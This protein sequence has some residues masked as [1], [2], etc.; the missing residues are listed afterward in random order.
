MEK[1]TGRHTAAMVFV[2]FCCLGSAV[3]APRGKQELVPSGHWVYDALTAVSLENG[4]RNFADCAPL[5]IAELQTYFDEIDYEKLSPAGK[6]QWSRIRDYFREQN[7]SFDSGILSLGIEPSFNPESYYKTNDDIDWVYDRYE[8]KAF[9]SVPAALSAG[10]WLTLGC[11]LHLGQNKGEMLHDDDYFNLPLDTQQLDVN[12]PSAAYF[13]TGYQFSDTSGA[14][15]QLGMGAQSVGRTATGSIIVSD[16]MTGASYGQFSLYSPNLKYVFTAT[17]LNVDKYMYMHRLDFRFFRKKLTFSVME[18][19]L[20]KASMELRYLNPFTIY[21]GMA[22]WRDYGSD[23]S[24]DGEYMCFKVDWTPSRYFRLYGLFAQDQ[25]QTPY[26]TENYGDS[27]TPNAMGGQLGIESFVPSEDG[28]VHFC[29]E[30]YYAQPYLYIKQSPEWSFMRTYTDNVGDNAIFY[31]WV[32]SPFG[33]D[34]IA[35]QLTLGYEKPGRWA[36]NATYLFMAQGEYAEKS[37]FGTWSS[38]DGDGNDAGSWSAAWPYPTEANGNNIYATTPT[39]TPKYTNRLSVRGTWYANDWLSF[40]L[41]PAYVII[42]NN[43]NSNG[44]HE[45]GNTDWGIECAFAVCCLLTKM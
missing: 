28:Y 9:L 26:E 2:M 6:N 25:F 19:T 34:T 21:H 7:W 10:N 8:R 40:T 20:T 45:T 39:G 43:T 37:I 24:G 23:D 14:S 15:F 33:P 17:Q 35:G 11:D 27:L 1:R 22:P 13:S 16:Y 3:A 18:A 41:Q 32:G 36:V 42:F 30:G 31:E 44:E 12:F 29:L 5:T 38:T 4:I